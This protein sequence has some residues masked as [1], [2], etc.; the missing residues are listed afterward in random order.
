MSWNSPYALNSPCVQYVHYNS[1]RPLA[2]ILWEIWGNS[3]AFAKYICGRTQYIP[4]CQNICDSSRSVPVHAQAEDFPHNLGR[5]VINHLFELRTL[6]IRTTESVI[7]VEL[8][9][10]ITVLFCIFHKNLLMIDDTVRIP[11]ISVVLWQATVECCELPINS[12]YWGSGKSISCN[13]L[14]CI[15]SHKFLLLWQS[16]R[17][18][19]Y[20][21]KITQELSFVC[22]F[23]DPVRIIF[24]SVRYVVYFVE[25][26]A[27]RYLL[28]LLLS[29][30]L[31]WILHDKLCFR[32][33]IPVSL[34]FLQFPTF[35]S[36]F[37]YWIL[38]RSDGICQYPQE[39]HLRMVLMQPYLLRAALLTLKL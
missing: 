23:W 21:L 16:H 37:L 15:I 25:S 30:R 12:P 38:K 20:I 14:L 26:D 31:I 17:Q 32:Y 29:N 28:F 34:A 3:I 36:P 1:T 39:S 27:L 22:L 13:N 4:A 33:D 2:R 5:F 10:R 24:Q 18:R 9:R 19:L 8:V 6:E 7:C 35:D 11:Y